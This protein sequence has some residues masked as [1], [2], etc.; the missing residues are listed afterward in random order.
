MSPDLIVVLVT[1]LVVLGWVGGG[2]WL[3]DRREAR[4]RRRRCAPQVAD[5]EVDGGF[6]PSRPKASPG[7]PVRL[8]FR[9]AEDGDSSW[10]DVEFPYA[11]VREHLPEGGTATLDLAPL[12][13]GEYA[14]FGAGRTMRGTLVVENGEPTTGSLR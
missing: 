14:F 10:D 13:P 3:A 1:V 2:L 8:R 12:E 9:R 11:W 5:I 4:E 7:R 6:S